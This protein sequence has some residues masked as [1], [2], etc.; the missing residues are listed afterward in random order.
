[1]LL[2]YQSY[3]NSYVFSPH[4]K[5]FYK[6][7]INS[8]VNEQLP[9]SLLIL[10]SEVH[11]WSIGSSTILSSIKFLTNFLNNDE[12]N[13]VKSFKHTKQCNTYIIHHGFLRVVLALYVNCSPKELIFTHNSYGKL[14]LSSTIQ[15]TNLKTVFCNSSKSD[16]LIVLTIST[17]YELGIDIEQ[18]KDTFD[19]TSITRYFSKEEQHQLA[20]LNQSSITDMR[21]GFYLGWTS[22]EAFIKCIGLGLSFPLK[23]FTV[24]FNLN[25]GAQLLA[26]DNAKYRIED[27]YMQ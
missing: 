24:N 17:D 12:L 21:N 10:P 6:G 22:K 4:L 2:L 3:L 9:R 26:I 11:V 14:Y 25:T 7:I 27:F 16:D 15:N 13:R 8:L 1:M 5:I 23:D 18:I 19:F 20:L